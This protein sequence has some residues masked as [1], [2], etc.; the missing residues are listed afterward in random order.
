MIYSMTGFAATRG[1]GA[2]FS[3]GWELRSVNGKGLDLRIRAPDWVEGLEVALRARLGQAVAR[4]NVTL[5]LRVQAEESGGRLSINAA[6]LEDVLSAM[7]EVERAAMAR[8]LNLAPARPADVMNVR[9]VLETATAEQDT[10]GLKAAL[11][12]DIEPLIESFTAMRAAEGQALAR[13]LGAQIDTVARL[14]EEAEKAADARRPEAEATLKAALARVM[15]NTDGADE[16]RIT[17]ELAMLAVKADVSEEIVRLRAHVDA[18][19]ALLQGGSP[20]GRKLEFLTQEFN[21]EANTLCAKAGSVALTSIGLD[22][23]AVIDQMREQVQNV[24]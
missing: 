5:N 22:L 14:T 1:S 6:Q 19:R 21:R 11:L 9:G 8:G 12:A 24:E 3:W 18:A 2:G 20:L 7:A 23:K 13:D 15:D 16:A 10:A 17:Q 4:G